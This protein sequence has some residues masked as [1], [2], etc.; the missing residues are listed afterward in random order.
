MSE[1]SPFHTEGGVKA[2]SV[3]EAAMKNQQ[4]FNG[5][6][7]TKTSANKRL[8]KTNARDLR[9]NRDLCFTDKYEILHCREF[10]GICKSCCQDRIDIY[11]YRIVCLTQICVTN[12]PAHLNP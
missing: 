3:D 12:L 9:A 6:V 4:G 8:I 1:E 5:S 11:K 2:V 10:I 7:Q